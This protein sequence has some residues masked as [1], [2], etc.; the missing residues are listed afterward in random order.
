MQI[1][2][3]RVIAFKHLSTE[4]FKT[5]SKREIILLL[6]SLIIYFITHRLFI[7]LNV[8]MKTYEGVSKSLEI[9]QK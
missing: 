6:L 2:Y 3:R 7:V 5:N 4:T 8:A 9:T 1:L